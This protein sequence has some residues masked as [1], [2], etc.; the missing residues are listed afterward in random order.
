[1][2]TEHGF[3]TSAAMDWT[4]SE[5]AQPM[6]VTFMFQGIGAAIAGKWCQSVG[7]RKAMTVAALCFGGG[8][9]IG[10]MGVEMHSMLLLN[11]GYGFFA[12]MGIGIAYTPPLQASR[13]THSFYYYTFA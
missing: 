12:G 9:M 7:A 11:V 8:H 5:V 3:V 6:I 1:M 13:T 2:M 10:S 4:F